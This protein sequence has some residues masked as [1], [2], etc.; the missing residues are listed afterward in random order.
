MALLSDPTQVTGSASQTTVAASPTDSPAVTVLSEASSQAN[1]SES[2]S[3]ESS[4]ANAPPSDAGQSGGAD[5]W[6][7]EKR[8]EERFSAKSSEQSTNMR[9][10]QQPSLKRRGHKPPVLLDAAI[11]VLLVLLFAIICRRM[12]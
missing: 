3:V 8:T 11:C 2:T 1:I 12:V 7:L 5:V 6:I 9:E 10:A 4:S